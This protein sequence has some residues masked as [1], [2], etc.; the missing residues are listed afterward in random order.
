MVFNFSLSNNIVY[1]PPC[2]LRELS[3]LSNR[4]HLIIL[5]I[6]ILSF[7]GCAD[8]REVVKSVPLHIHPEGEIERNDFYVSEEDDVIGRLAAIKLEKGD[9][10][11]DIARHFSL[12]INTVSSANPGIDTW[13]PDP[14]GRLLLPLSFTLPDTHRQ[15][16]V[17]NLAAMRLFYFRKDGK[18]L[19]VSTY[20]VG[21]GTVEQPSPMGK[22]YI[23]RKKSRPT[24][25]VPAVIARDHRKKGD[26]L[27]AYVP[28]GPLNPLGEYALYLSK[29]GFLVH[30]T[31][32]PASIGLR[33]TYGCIRLYPEDIKR[34]YK[35]TPVK[36]PVRI[37]NQPYLVG[38]RDGIIYIEA[39][40]P[41]EESG[42][43]ELKKAYE[44]LRNIEKKSGHALDW[45]KVGK[46]MGEARGFPVPIFDIRDG[47]Q[48]QFTDT[49][50]LRRPDKFYGK[51]EVPEL[52]TDAWYVLAATLRDRVNAQRLAAI[53]NHQGPPIPARVVSS[54]DRHRVLT[55]PFTDRREAKDA[56]KRL[57]IDL[58]IDGI[59]VE[60]TKEGQPIALLVSE[61]KMNLY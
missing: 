42:T 28:P 4:L 45:K 43:A 14:G 29:S 56:A 49:I 44:K 47:S 6:F 22:M 35:N 9:T 48:T 32:K 19:T 16:I 23:V 20:P 54:M 41:L 7:P 2:R 21:I 10:L 13:V 11:P 58:E 30:G 46:V 34:L 5:L 53:I 40:K 24:W 61:P 60:P 50:K 31:N 55:G 33:A 17:I 37:V 38:R 18:R 52:K 59:L 25:Y 51:P 3:P 8:V 26:P 15:G 39:H 57:K 27:P 36:T 12:G 1:I